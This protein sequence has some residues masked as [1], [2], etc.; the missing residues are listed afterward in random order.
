MFLQ[1]TLIIFILLTPISWFL[2][3]EQFIWYSLIP[4]ILWQLLNQHRFSINFET[5]FIFLFL[6]ALVLS[7]ISLLDVS[8]K[9]Y[10]TYIRDALNYFLL[11]SLLIYIPY[12]KANKQE[13]QFFINVVPQYL[14]LIFASLA[15]ITLVFWLIDFR[16]HFQAPITHVLPHVITQTGFAEHLL[17]KS[18]LNV[19]EGY[20]LGNHYIRAKGVFI[21][22][23]TFSLALEILIPLSCYLAFYHKKQRGFYFF[24]AFIMFLALLITFSRSGLLTLLAGFII[25]LYLW[26]DYF[27]S[28]YISLYLKII[29]MLLAT[30]III[31]FS[32]YLFDIFNNILYARGEGNVLVRSFLY[33][34]SIRQVLDNPLGFGT[35]RD[36]LY[37]REIAP[38]GSHSQYISI[39][40]KYGFIGFL[41]YI[42]FLISL[43]ARL[44]TTLYQSKAKRDFTSWILVACLAW[45]F[46][47]NIL[48]Q[49]TIELSLD[50]TA[51]IINIFFWL[52]IIYFSIQ[53]KNNS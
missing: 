51:F 33:T 39:F 1:K 34:E 18:F 5:I 50:V 38:L 36:V 53:F 43:S 16:F 46:I 15:F 14:V 27:L 6:I 3:L 52:L 30:V 26:I 42:I 32:D 45:A 19:E 20:L 22:A 8:I 21:Y 48:H 4:L 2:G 35:Y 17:S 29:M 9:R 47:T 28:N 24:L 37:S 10:I 40:Y 7:A 13:I 12:Q 44:L 31:I 41:G 11:L 23:N 25:F 49:I